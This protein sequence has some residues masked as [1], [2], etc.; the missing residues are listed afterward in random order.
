[1]FLQRTFERRTVNDWNLN[2][3]IYNWPLIKKHLW[4]HT[5]LLTICSVSMFCY[6]KK[7]TYYICLHIW[8]LRG[9]E[10]RARS[11]ICVRRRVWRHNAVLYFLW[12][13]GN[14]FYVHHQHICRIHVHHFLG[15]FIFFPDVSIIPWTCNYNSLIRIT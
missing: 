5:I 14:N 7:C 13:T 10:C 15:L 1:M 11:S 3:S 4:K 8:V 2:V 9:H 6:R 12:N